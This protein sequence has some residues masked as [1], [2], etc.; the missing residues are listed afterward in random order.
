MINVFLYVFFSVDCLFTIVNIIIIQEEDSDSEYVGPQGGSNFVPM[1][2]SQ[3]TFDMFSG[4]NES[5]GNVIYYVEHIV[6]VLFYSI[7]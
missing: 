1:P 2:S 4:H 3:D 6:C 5:E 7:L